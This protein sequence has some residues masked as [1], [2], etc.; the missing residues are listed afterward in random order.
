[1]PFAEIDN[2]NSILVRD[3]YDCKDVLAKMGA[4]WDGDEKAWRVVLTVANA[5]KLL[6]SVPDMTLSANFENKIQEQVDREKRL[7]ELTVLAKND[8]Q[9]GMKV[10]GLKMAPYN[11]QKIG[12]MFAVANGCGMLLA[13]E[14]GLGKAGPLS[15]PVLTPSG[16]R[17]M[18]DLRVG[19]YVVGRNGKATE[20]LGVFPQVDR[21][22]YRVT[23][24]DGSYTR[25][26]LD[27]LWAVQTTND[28]FMQ[29]KDWRVVSVRQILDGK[30]IPKVC[31]KKGRTNY[32]W[33]PSV[34]KPNG[35]RNLCIPMVEP[36]FYEQ[37]VIG[38]PVDPY[39][40]GVSL[41]DGWISKSGRVGVTK[42]DDTEPL[43]MLVD[44]RCQTNR[45][46][47]GFS[48]V[49]KPF[50]AMGLAGK[51]SWEKFIPKEYLVSSPENRLKLLQGLM[52]T[53]GYAQPDG[54]SE[55][56][57]TS[58]DLVLGVVELAQ[59]LGGVAR[60]EEDGR[61][62]GFEYKG[63]KK[64]GR[65]SW[66]VNVRLPEGVN[67]FLLPRKA[68]QYKLPEEYMPS[69][70][71]ESIER[72]EDEDLVCI[73]V[74][75][76]DHLYVTKDFI[77]THN[78]LQS[79]SYCQ[80]LRAKGLATK[81]LII[82]PASLKYNWPIEIEKF[83]DA[84]YVVIDASTPEG[85]VA[86]WMRDDVYFVITNYELVIE[87]LFGGRDYSPKKG[88]TP[89][90]R[91]RKA[92]TASKAAIRQKLLAPIRKRVWSAIIADECFPYDAW[93]DTNE[94]PIRIGEIV[95]NQ[96]DVLV[97]S[98]DTSRGELSYK[99]IERWIQKDLS[100]NLV[101]VEHEYGKFICTSNHRIWTEQ[102]GYVEAGNLSK[103]D[104]SDL[105]VLPKAL[106]TYEEGENNCKV[107]FA[108][109]L[110]GC[111]QM[112]RSQTGLQ[113]VQ[114]HICSATHEG[115]ESEVLL[116]TMQCYL[117][118][119][120]RA[121]LGLEDGEDAGEVCSGLQGGQESNRICQ[122]EDKESR[123]AIS[124]KGNRRFCQME[125]KSSDF[126]STR[127]ETTNYDSS[128]ESSSGFGGGMGLGVCGFGEREN[129]GSNSVS[130]SSSLLSDRHR[131]ANV[132]DCSGGGRK[133][134]QN[135]Q[136]EGDRREKKQ[137]FVS[138]RVVGVKV[139][140]RSDHGRL[141]ICG[142]EN[143][144]VYN[145]E[146]EDNH[147]YI[148]NAVLVSNCHALKTPTAKR[149]KAVKSLKARF[150]M[151]LTGT[152]MDGRLE[153]LHSVMGFI[154]PGLLGS[155]DQFFKRHVS[156]DFFG[157]ITGYKNIAEVRD[158][159]RPF[160]LRRLKKDVLKDLPDKVYKTIL[161]QL[162][163]SES[164]IYRELA[165]QA[166]EVTE[167]AEAV[168]ALL[169]C[170]QF[171]NWPSMIDPNCSYHSKMDEFMSVVQE[172][173]G[174][175]GHKALVFTQYKEMLNIIA[176]KLDAAGFKYLRIDGDTPKLRRAEMQAEFNSSKAIDLMIGTEAM[177]TGLNF[178][179][180]DYVINYDDSWAPSFM[181]QRED[182]C[183]RIGQKNVVSVIG[184][185]CVD[186][187]EARVKHVIRQKEAVT[188]E[189]LGD[190]DEFT[191]I[192]MKAKDLVKLL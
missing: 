64:T 161:V 122:D 69:R 114:N 13:D 91:E 38:L 43:R 118:D 96:L 14:M 176:E 135:E 145:L 10:A 165:S 22:V 85:R 105:W 112:F 72:V 39:V 156:Q 82:T 42:G 100:G 23:F 179:S 18:G 121:G 104:S 111:E 92:K 144:R 188:R 59:S 32:L 150:R 190:G 182:R 160:F 124:S 126:S 48:L 37:Q 134:P 170:R 28:R 81:V 54:G 115:Q 36:V 189:T 27:H 166:H 185:E 154:A 35:D 76:D 56:S 9:V 169:R 16:W 65:K 12:V 47:S 6:D 41:G 153:E 139:L 117:A 62:T 86:Q 78:T 167:E 46:A 181:R 52:D 102:H 136:V 4:S 33:T 129:G 31:T 191:A 106:S 157:S 20:V 25:C 77:V 146:V 1:M 174:D 93:V 71:I 180:A 73:R 50:V 132:E 116:K 70:W 184:F 7:E 99:K 58:C 168:V 94:G 173:V 152:P 159:I 49:I 125:G 3:S 88:D 130:S 26:G 45:I 119:K 107:L 109:V 155:R 103:Q 79:I 192:G 158:K 19:E 21:T 171:C 138:S 61:N 187:V 89:E 175:N 120:K 29:A 15:E 17:K 44:A 113:G 131:D 63:E 51:R 143:P 123:S 183:H 90:V 2:S 151:G 140:E 60:F 97:L 57:S 178:T 74:A 53:D 24:S 55:F 30:P 84:P 101:E 137:G 67:P 186:T 149:S 5:E 172:V 34:N 75:A 66:R 163:T 128:K 164:R 68:D 87:D 8:S 83:T 177:S 110:N 108:P 127:R 98:C 11:Y 142:C 147:N 80:Y 141:G 133:H 40:L 162:T 95:E 148:A